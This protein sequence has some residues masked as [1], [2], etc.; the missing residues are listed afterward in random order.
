MMSSPLTELSGGSLGIYDHPPFRYG[1]LPDG[2]SSSW[3]GRRDFRDGAMA[4]SIPLLVPPQMDD[5]PAIANKFDYVSHD[6]GENSRSDQEGSNKPDKVQRRLAQNREAARKSRLRKKAYVQQLESSRLKLAQLEQE[7][8]RARLQGI[9]RGNVLDISCRFGFSRPMNSG[10]MT[11][12]IE[13]AHWVEEQRRKNGELWNAMQTKEAGEIELQILVDSYLKHYDR[14]F[15]MKMDAAKANVFYIM[16]GTWRSSAERFFLWIGGFRPSELLNVLMLQIE[17][18]T[19]QQMLDVFNLRRSCKQAEDALSQG[20]DKLQQNLAHE[21]ATNQ[22]GGGTD[23]RSQLAAAMEKIEA[24]ENFINQADHLRQQTMRRMSRILT[25][26]QAARA[27]LGLGD[28]S[29]RLRALSS[30]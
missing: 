28:Y 18:M 24:W 1:H 27:L 30:L 3:A 23:Y 7:L 14:L 21:V 6:S 8:D 5:S 17:P 26:H 15:R 13:Y 9:Y 19:D 2:R 16:S 20:M 29:D 4:N 12:D 11:F 10:I 25:I 22:I